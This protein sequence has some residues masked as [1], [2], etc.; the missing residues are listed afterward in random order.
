[1]RIFLTGGTGY[2]GS[3]VLDSLVRAGHRVDALV[4]NSERAALVQARGAHPVIGD[5]A[6]PATW[7]E[8]ASGAE[9][10]IH[11]ALDHGARLVPADEAV[12]ATL[13]SLPPRDGGRF[14]IYTSGIWVLGSTS[15]LGADEAA[16]YDP[17]EISAWRVPHERRVLDAQG[18]GLRTVVVRPGIVYGGSDG[19]VGDLFRDAANG[20]IRVVGEGRNHW[21]LVYDRDLGDLYA[22]LAAAQ[23]ASGVFHANDEGDERVADL[24]SAIAAQ[25]PSA[26]SIR[27]IPLPEARQKMGAY[28]DAL[29]RDQIL[30]SP[31]AHALGWRPTLRSVAENAARLFEEW[32]HGTQATEKH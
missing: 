23:D 1:M 28:A 25:V 15:N 17:V 4:R 27:H 20:L 11:T 14:L 32:R 10:A 26:P 29:A 22:R 13:T 18:E 3:A 9:G 6:A 8:A 21:P 7:A 16:P 31:R 2:I 19:I 30:R 24:V 12:I 5:L